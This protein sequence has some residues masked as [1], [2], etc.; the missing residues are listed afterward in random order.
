MTIDTTLILPWSTDSADL[1][2]Q[3]LTH[4]ARAYITTAS[5]DYVGLDLEGGTL[6][7]DETRSPR[8]TANLSCRVPT[9]QALLDRIDPRIGG[10]RLRVDV[11]YFRPD[12]NED[13]QQIVDLGLRS[14]RVTRPDDIMTITAA[15]DE[16]LVIDA[17]PTKS[18]TVTNASTTGAIS[19]VI[20]QVLTTTPVVDVGG[21]T[22]PAVSGVLFDD[23]W[24]VIN[25]LADRIEKQVFDNGLRTWY[26]NSTP[27]LDTPALEVKVGEG[28]T[29]IGSDAGLDRDEGF[30]NFVWLRYEWTDGSNVD[31]KIDATQRIQTGPYAAT[32]GNYRIFK[33][34]R[35]VAT[36]QTE[37]DN[38]AAALVG[39][40][41]TRGRSFEVE[42]ISAYWLRPGHTIEV[43]L[44]LGSPE[45]HLVTAVTFDLRAGTMRVTTRL[46][47]N[48]GTIGA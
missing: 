36:T 33:Q 37:A 14:R 1:I 9:D 48:T 42:C 5:G 2:T 6:T 44:P 43:T 17:G 4:V 27:L 26:I 47:D 30:Y 10:T 46:P 29:I 23:R 11:G 3:T 21:P 32:T 39:R 16:A 28:G 24:D 31:H 13:V 35:Q 41:V 38:A 45:Q 8:V 22:G 7:W 20:N 12:G 34:E 18:G 40:T 19:A 25:D 15:S